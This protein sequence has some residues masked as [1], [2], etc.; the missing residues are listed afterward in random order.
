MQAV[1]R[2]SDLEADD[3]LLAEW[4]ALLAEMDRLVRAQTLCWVT[5]ELTHICDPSTGPRG[6]LP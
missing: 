4:F 6:A 2:D 3:E 5:G 1:L